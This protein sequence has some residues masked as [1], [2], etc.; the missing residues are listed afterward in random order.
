M[1]SVFQCV[2]ECILNETGIL[3]DRKFMPNVAADMARKALGPK[4]VW[5]LVVEDA[6]KVCNEHGIK[7][8]RRNANFP[9][10]LLYCINISSL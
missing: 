3:V 7:F 4:N 6:L 5:L 9:N 8:S 10:F 1:W 2:T